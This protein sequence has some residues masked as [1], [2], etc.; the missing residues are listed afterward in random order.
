M[1][2]KDNL[3]TF[4]INLNLTQQPSSQL[5]DFGEVGGV[6]GETAVTPREGKGDERPS[7]RL[8]SSGRTLSI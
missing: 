2:T 1:S 6:Q 4:P 8:Q 5:F 7:D 3:G